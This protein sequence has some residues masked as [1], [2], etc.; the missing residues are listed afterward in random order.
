MNEW[1]C[2]NSGCIVSNFN[3]IKDVWPLGYGT[4][5]GANAGRYF[6]WSFYLRPYKGAGFHANFKRVCLEHHKIFLEMFEK[7]MAGDVENM[8]FTEMYAIRN[9]GRI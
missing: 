5:K 2:S 6:V 4:S 9:R 8:E 1:N 7:E 3:S